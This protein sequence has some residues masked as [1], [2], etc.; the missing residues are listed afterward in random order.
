MRIIVNTAVDPGPNRIYQRL[1][2]LMFVENHPQTPYY[3]ILEEDKWED[4]VVTYKNVLLEII[5]Q[6]N[7][8]KELIIEFE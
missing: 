4:L 3:K 7:I 2:Y 6:E 5:N 8:D 1:A